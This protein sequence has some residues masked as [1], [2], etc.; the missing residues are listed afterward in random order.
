MKKYYLLLSLLAMSMTISHA[1]VAS[2]DG[3]FSSAGTSDLILQTNTAPRLTILNANGNVG[4][5]KSNPGYLLDVNGVMNAAGFMLNGIPM[6]SSKW[7]ASASDIHF[8]TGRVGIGIITPAEA[9][10]VNGNILS[11]NFSS[12]TGYFNAT[13]SSNLSFFTNSTNRLTV[14]NSN[15]NV[16]INSPTPDEKLHI[17]NGNII[18]DNLIPVL[19]TGTGGSELNRYL[20]IANS[21]TLSSPSGLKSGGLLVADNFGYANPSK[22]DLVVKG[23]VGIGTTLG[24]NPNN[25]TLAVNGTVGARKVQVETA[26]GTWPDYVFAPEYALPD[27]KEVEQFINIHRHLKDVPSAIEAENNG[28]DLGSMDVVLLKKVEELTLYIIQQQKEI[29]DLRGK[30]EKVIEGK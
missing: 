8:T 28:H 3:T 19:F 23:R 24:S 6:V 30:L 20:Q 7:V 11:D 9:L 29:D 12:T 13:G 4:I 10:H 5:G 18:L 27:L 15:G 16:G 2:T 26:S 22:N 14:L 17:T 25:Y 21:T 1:Q